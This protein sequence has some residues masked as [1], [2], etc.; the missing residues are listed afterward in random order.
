MTVKKF[1]QKLQGDHELTFFYDNG[2]RMADGSIFNIF[3]YPPICKT[4]SD[5]LDVIPYLNY[6]LVS[7]YPRQTDI[8]LLVKEK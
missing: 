2:K 5:S 4:P 3:T 1:I 8:I 7:F 6:E